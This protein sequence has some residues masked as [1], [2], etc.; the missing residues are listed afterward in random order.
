M[1]SIIQISQVN[2]Q[3]RQTLAAIIAGHASEPQLKSVV[4]VARRQKDSP[5]ALLGDGPYWKFVQGCHAP[6]RRIE[7]MKWY[8][9]LSDQIADVNKALSA[10][11]DIA[12]TGSIIGGKQ[13]TSFQI[14]FENEWPEE[15]QERLIRTQKMMQ[16]I[17]KRCV[18]MM[19]K[20]GSYAPAIQLRRN[21]RGEMYVDLMDVPPATMFRNFDSNGEIDYSRYWVQVINGRVHGS[22][23]MFNGRSNTGLPQWRVP[24]F[25]LW[26]DPVRAE[27]T[28]LYGTSI[29]RPFGGIGLKMEAAIDALVVARLSRAA[30]RYK[31]SIDVSDV[32]NDQA[33]IKARVRGYQQML[34]RQQ[35]LFNEGENSN[36]YHRPE[37]PDADI[38]VPAGKDLHYDVDTISGDANLPRVQDLEF[39]AKFYFG[40]LGLPPEYLGHERSQGGRSTL[41]QIDVHFAR[42]ARDVQLSACAAFEHIAMVDMILGGFDPRDFPIRCVP[43]AIGA[44]DELLQA[45]VRTLQATLIKTLVDAGM[46]V[47]ENPKWVLETFMLMD[48]ELVGMTE[49]DLKKLFSGTPKVE[50]GGDD[51]ANPSQ[52]REFL[53][54]TSA[55]LW[56]QLRQCHDLLAINSVVSAPD[57]P[58]GAG[59]D[60][61]AAKESIG[62]AIK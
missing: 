60:M 53:Q 56:A 32:E 35:A 51:P 54:K 58:T 15:L 18:R 61:D 43:P 8:D 55:D 21:H 20:Y 16:G 9:Y 57:M 52:A 40:A 50:G 29:L 7:E 38:F 10:Y 45:Q 48:D 6:S 4:P 25:A 41:M 19:C 28:V 26:S 49:E 13:D 44:R 3:I 23:E 36:S 62:S 59:L 37:V 27:H 14:L 34:S 33:A 2:Q 22:N 31:W 47:A 1:Q 46:N 30:M 39:L 17:S 12:T 24:H 11:A 42:T 5:H